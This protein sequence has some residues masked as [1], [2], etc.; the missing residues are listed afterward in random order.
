MRGY[1]GET[2]EVRNGGKEREG[3]GEA[4]NDPHGSGQK[5]E[6]DDEGAAGKEISKGTDEEETGGIAGLHQGCDGRSFF[7]AHVKGL[8]NFVEDGLV[9]VEIGYSEAAGLGCQRWS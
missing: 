2:A 4:E 1:G 5:Y 7:E 8:G 6:T 3:G 9:V